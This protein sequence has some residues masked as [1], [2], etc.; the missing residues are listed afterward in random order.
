ML[1]TLLMPCLAGCFLASG[2]P[3]HHEK[4]SASK[5]PEK[6]QLSLIPPEAA[7]VSIVAPRPEPPQPDL[8]QVTSRLMKD[9]VTGFVLVPAG[10]I[11]H[12][13]ADKARAS[14]KEPAG[15]RKRDIGAIRYRRGHG[16]RVKEVVRDLGDV[17][18]V[19]T[20]PREDRAHHC[21][22]E[23]SDDRF[24][25][26]AWVRKRDLV[27][28]TTR[29]VEHRFP[30]GTGFVLNSGVAISEAE[31]ARKGGWAVAVE[32]VVLELPVP[33]EALGLS[34]AH[35]DPF[36]FERP[37]YSYFGGGRRRSRNTYVDHSAVL[38]LDGEVI[39]KGGLL[40]HHLGFVPGG[41]AD[42][43]ELGSPC[44]KL[45]L[46]LDPAKF[47]DGSRGGG[48]MGT[49]GGLSLSRE[50]P[51]YRIEA[52]TEVFWPDGRK[53]GE[54]VQ[55]FAWKSRPGTGER[56]CFE[57]GT[58]VDEDLCFRLADIKDNPER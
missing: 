29:S 15:V 45:V 5:I 48:G 19:R 42:A 11:L 40:S 53:A 31:Y 34:Y 38:V 37:R 33:D 58:G 26:T 44:L 18:E 52:G 8:S 13:S 57:I 28:V 36:E 54:V 3:A 25:L 27:P 10:K 16:V 46:R 49:V 2:C 14:G 1:R 9:E 30:D 50:T 22:M 41:E 12:S 6:R 55:G 4:P 20:L 17:V 51:P 24:R 43:V 35:P 32:Q 23:E 47:S 39:G 56:A 7:H 21:Y